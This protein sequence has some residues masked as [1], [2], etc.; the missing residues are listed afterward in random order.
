VPVHNWTLVDDGIFHA[1]HTLWI[2][3]VNAVLN[4]GLLPKGFYAL[5]EQHA[6][7][8]IADILTLHASEAGSSLPP[9][10]CGVA[11][12]AAP[13]R[14]RRRQT[15]E[16]SLRQ[17]ARSLAIRHVS[18]HRLVALL[19]II[20][21]GNKDRPRRVEE[22][23]DK[24]IE[25]LRSDVNLLVIDLFPPGEHDRCWMHGAIRQRLLDAD[26]PDYDIDPIEPLTLAA[27]IADRQVDAYIEHVAVGAARPPMPLSLRDDRY[28]NV[29]LEETY[30]AAYRGMPEFWRDVLDGRKSGM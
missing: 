5:P 30:Q 8:S 10:D 16:S 9:S 24:A 14:V 28:V 17:R 12:A 1:F 11:L 15:I 23:A 18:G 19:E 26:E 25:A 2:A 7:A 13:P 22:F 20:S 29:P 21:P 27:Y 3:S 6:G 4:D